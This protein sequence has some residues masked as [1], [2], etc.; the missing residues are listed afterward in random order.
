[1]NSL[2]LM[3]VLGVAKQDRHTRGRVS[4]PEQGEGCP[5]GRQA[6]QEESEAE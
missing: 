5:G 3:P 6:W 1:M 4:E 2:V